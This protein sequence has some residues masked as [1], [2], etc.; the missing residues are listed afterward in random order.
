MHV[1]SSEDEAQSAVEVESYDTIDEDVVMQTED[2]MVDEVTTGVANISL[3][4]VDQLNEKLTS[5]KPEDEWN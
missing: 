3:D 1:I 5:L 4:E 2:I